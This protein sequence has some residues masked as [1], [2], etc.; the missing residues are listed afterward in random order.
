MALCKCPIC[1]GKDKAENMVKIGARHY[2]IGECEQKKLE[3]DEKR[4]VKKDD[5]DC[6]FEYICELY[7][8]NKPTG[9]MFKQLSMF[10]DDYGYTD[11]GITLTLK[12]YYEILGNTV[13]E[14]T[15]LGII[16]YYYEQAKK[17]YSEMWDVE[18]YMENFVNEEKTLILDV[19]IPQDT[20]KNN[21]VKQ[22][23][24][25]NI[26]WEDEDE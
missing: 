19:K 6:L 18:D 8:L 15:G 14:D 5:W 21:F 2:H 7:H 17:Y 13:L 16:P 11:A 9:F 25:K 23:T 1:G 12:Y 3:E 26:N 20:L 22:L 4:K 24:F 10:R